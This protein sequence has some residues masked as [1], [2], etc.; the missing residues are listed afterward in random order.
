[1][2]NDQSNEDKNYLIFLIEWKER[3][4]YDSHLEWLELN[5]PELLKLPEMGD[6]QWMS[7]EDVKELIASSFSAF[8]NQKASRQYYSRLFSRQKLERNF[9]DATRTLE[10]LS[11]DLEAFDPRYRTTFFWAL[12]Y[13]EESL[14]KL[15]EQYDFSPLE[16]L[17]TKDLREQFIRASTSRSF[18]KRTALFSVVTELRL[19]WDDVEEFDKETKAKIQAYLDDEVLVRSDRTLRYEDETSSFRVEGPEPMIRVPRFL[20]ERLGSSEMDILLELK[21]LSQEVIETALVFYKDGNYKELTD[22][23]I[24]AEALIELS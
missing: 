6:I 11:A 16:K 4:L 10:S 5:T 20:I 13:Y 2:L 15:K 24:A 3:L 19:D 8:G 1:M 17:S 22:A 21:C 12:S 14:K 18:V 23:V 7:K 9:G